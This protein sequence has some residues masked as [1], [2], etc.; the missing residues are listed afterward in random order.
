MKKWITWSD[1]CSR[2]D[3]NEYDLAEII[4]GGKLQSFHGEDFSALNI[5]DG[6]HFDESPDGQMSLL[7][8]EP[9]TVDLLTKLI[10]RISDVEKFEMENG[11]SIQVLPTDL[12]QQIL[13]ENALVAHSQDEL[14]EAIK[15]LPPPLNLSISSPGKVMCGILDL[16]DRIPE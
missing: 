1:L 9:L 15:P 6:G 8:K 4:F 16:R 12:P 14:D 10:F 7:N 5:V 11:I 13:T 2:W 3:I